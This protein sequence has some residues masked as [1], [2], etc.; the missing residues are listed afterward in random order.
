MKSQERRKAMSDQLKNIAFWIAVV[1]LL[2]FGWLI[3]YLLQKVGVEETHWNRMVFL[4]KG[5]EAIALAAVGYLFG[6][7]V[8][9]ERADKAESRASTAKN[10]TRQA[11]GEKQRHEQKLSDLIKLIETKHER[12]A[13]AHLAGLLERQLVLEPDAENDLPGVT[14][15]IA[16]RRSDSRTVEPE[17]DWEDLVRFTSKLKAAT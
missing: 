15:F 5:V 14:D 12:K 6:R 17:S 9:R 1:A 2:A 10:D 4:H 7:E 13:S 11:H 16:R 8:H 3:T